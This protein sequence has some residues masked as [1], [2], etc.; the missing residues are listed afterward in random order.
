M[1][2]AIKWVFRT[3]GR[4][5]NTIR[6]LIINLLF[7]LVLVMAIML[8]SSKDDGPIMPNSAALTLTL[9]GPIL[10]TEST[11]SP[12]RFAERWLS[13]DDTPPPL[14]LQQIKTALE[15][16][17]H[18]ERINAVVLNLQEMSETSLTKLDEVG[19]ALADFKTSGKPIYAMGDN[20]TQGQYYLAAHADE[21]LLNSAGSVT[22]Q[23]L[24]VYRLYYKN[25]FDKFD[26]T[27]HVFRVGTYKSFVEP[28][29]RDDMSADSKE[30]TRRWLDQLWAHY[31][32]NVAKLRN[33]PQDHISPSAEQLLSRLTA[34]KGN[35]A[36]YALQQGLV[37]RLATREEMQS[38]IA[39]HVGWNNQE[40]HYMSVDVPAYLSHEQPHHSTAPAV[41]LISASGAIMS[42][43]R[44][45]NTINDEHLSKLIEQARRDT[46]IQALVLRVD[47]PGGSAFAAEQI[48]NSLLRFKESGKPLVVSMGSTAASGGYW[49]AADAD[50]I[51]AAPTTL[52]G[53]IGVFGLFLTFEEA[54]NKLG[55]NTDGVGTTPFV[56]AGLTTGLPEST[57]QVIQLGVEHV[58]DRF[59][60]IVAKGRHLDTAQVE[61]AAQGHVWTGIDAKKL[62]LVDELGSL[63]DALA[64][65]ANLANVG[66]FKVKRVQLP[67][68]AKERLINQL[69]GD[70]QVL[71][72]WMLAALPATLRPAG[73]QLHNELSALQ[74][75]DDAR[76]Q[77]V[78][79]VPC[80]AF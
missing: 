64:A 75:F 28:Y 38:T 49:I 55:L 72:D 76:G 39:E 71:S 21:V 29:L 22:I 65:A 53:S 46:D 78:L 9:T 73:E 52:T 23:G 32:R 57:K 56:G 20:Y 43:Q 58:Y 35:P 54:F 77:Y 4:V 41:G 47:S 11:M 12:R 40:Q 59:V 19:Q 14:T 42:G 61:A 10:E 31:Q 7:L 69:L 15:R 34:A 3:L 45:P 63:E 17:R 26:I 80:Q 1:W 36:Q 37:D 24:G 48:R 27:P 74:Q 44:T 79:C 25:A 51:Y 60:D 70:N 33:I 66:E 2:A 30:D 5:L 18:D 13:G 6:L 67:V 68:S 8:F 16:A 62:G 50:K